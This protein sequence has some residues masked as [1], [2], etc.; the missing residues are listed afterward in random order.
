[1]SGKKDRTIMKL[2]N[3]L[4]KTKKA[5]LFTKVH[6]F[7]CESVNGKLRFYVYFPDTNKVEAVIARDTNILFSPKW[8]SVDKL[9]IQ[10]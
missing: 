8:E 7:I 9:V 4:R 2:E 5:V 1:M 3:A 10:I 6:K